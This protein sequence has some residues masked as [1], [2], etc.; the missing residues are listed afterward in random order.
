MIVNLTFQGNLKG[1]CGDIYR[2]NLLEYSW[3]RK[4]FVWRCVIESSRVLKSVRTRTV[5]EDELY[6][7]VMTAINKLLAGGNNIDKDS[8]R[9]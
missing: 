3:Q 2:E 9:E 5:K 8:G 6:G 4:E 1:D 7:A